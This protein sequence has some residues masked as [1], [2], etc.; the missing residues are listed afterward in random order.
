MMPAAVSADPFGVAPDHGA[1]GYTNSNSDPAPYETGGGNRIGMLLPNSS[2]QTVYPTTECV[3]PALAKVDYLVEDSAAVVGSS[4]AQPKMAIAH[5]TSKPD[6]VYVEAQVGA[7]DSGGNGS[8]NPLGVTPDWGRRVGSYFYAVGQNMDNGMVRIGHIQLPFARKDHRFAR[9]DDDHDGQH[10]GNGDDD[11]D[12]VKDG[13]D[14]D[15]HHESRDRHDNETVESG[16]SVDYPMEADAN[17]TS[18][19]TT[20]VA[21]DLGQMMAVEVYN[22]A[23]QLVAAPLPA[24]GTAVVTIVPLTVGTYTVRVKNLGITPTA[25]TTTTVASAL[26]PLLP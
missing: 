18:L 16:Q 20:A 14:H 23:G 13:D 3:T 12:G 1:I 17:T 21:S 7:G 22:P 24:P 8:W 9:D 10:H 4:P 15:D 26:W 19:T 2:M 5:V 25:F 6:G 11:D